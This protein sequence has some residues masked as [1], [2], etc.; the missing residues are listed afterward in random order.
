MDPWGIVE[1]RRLDLRVSEDLWR[2]LQHKFPE[3]EVVINDVE[4]FVEKAE[5]ETFNTAHVGEDWFEAYVSS[6][7]TIYHTLLHISTR[8]SEACVT[9]S[10]SYIF[11]SHMIPNLRTFIVK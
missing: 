7:Y 11:I 6:R 2:Q 5:N 4:K 8:T 9:L 1:N 3:C 10:H